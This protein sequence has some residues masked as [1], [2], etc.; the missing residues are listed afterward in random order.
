MGFTGR[1]LRLTPIVWFSSSSRRRRRSFSHL[2][3][4]ARHMVVVVPMDEVQAVDAQRAGDGLI[5]RRLHEAAEEGQAPGFLLVLGRALD[6]GT[7]GI[8]LC[9]DGGGGGGTRGIPTRSVP[10]QF[11]RVILLR[12]PPSI[13]GS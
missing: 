1:G 11:S 8:E 7:P 10:D 5:P 6:E 3:P 2:L 4:H 9:K 12:P 13:K